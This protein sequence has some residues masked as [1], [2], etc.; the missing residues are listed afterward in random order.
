METLYYGESARTCFDRG[1][2]H[3]TALEKMDLESPL[4][5]HHAQDHPQE[6]PRFE[7][8]A[9]SFHD[10]PLHRQCEEAHLIE[11]FT[12]AKIMNRKG[13]WGHNLP[14]KLSIEGEGETGQV[15]RGRPTTRSQSQNHDVDQPEPKSKRMR[16][17]FQPPAQPVDS[18]K[19]APLTPKQ[20]LDKLWMNRHVT[21]ARTNANTDIS[22]DN[23]QIGLTH[24]ICA[25][26]DSNS[27]I[28]ENQ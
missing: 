15:K 20:I 8:K 27:A 24:K 17:G 10:E 5:E 4:V 9:K 12:G 26:Q 3:L 18:Q 21:D 7:M 25:R 23:T 22:P 1:V 28:S 13:E 19:P 14:P 11:A 2:K 6:E 16:I